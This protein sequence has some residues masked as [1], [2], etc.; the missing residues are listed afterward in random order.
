M[1]LKNITTYIHSKETAG[2]VDGPGLRYVLF[3][4]GCPLRCKYCHNPDSWNCEKGKLVNVEEIYKDII[5]YKSFMKFSNGG[6]TA[7]GGEPLL[8]K[9]FLNKLFQIL[10]NDNIH[11]T[12]DT[13]GFVDIDEDLENLLK[14]TDLVMLDIKHLNSSQHKWLTNQENHKTLSFLNHLKEN[15]IKTWIR[16][17]VLPNF[18]DS[19]EYTH[20]FAKFIKDY[21]N[22][23]LIEL[24]PYH[25]IGKYKWQELNIPY[26]LEDTI[27]PSNDTMQ[28]IE[29]ILNSYNI[30]T[31][32]AK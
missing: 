30:K 31:L 2:A 19:E 3:L 25:D 15:N 27:P 4:Q 20:E 23:E 28:K 7:S 29:D 14:Y 32:R 21:K 16:W 9:K 1:E 6:F 12:I 22:V 18:N 11:T 17:V 8:H 26:K 10:K 13:S 24:L 5:S